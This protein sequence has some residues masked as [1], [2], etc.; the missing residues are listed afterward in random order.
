MAFEGYPEFPENPVQQWVA[1]LSPE[2]REYHE[3]EVAQNN[4]GMIDRGMEV[5][6]QI[7]EF[8]EV[9][10]EAKLYFATRVARVINDSFEEGV[11]FG[12]DAAGEHRRISF[13]RYY[14]D[15]EITRLGGIG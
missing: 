2:D 8:A 11:Q 13:D 5:F 1:G 9:P 3:E 15:V 12:L 14:S 10:D 4:Q 7:P 6:A